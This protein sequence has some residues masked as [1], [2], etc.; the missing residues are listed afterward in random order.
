MVLSEVYDNWHEHR[1]SFA[2]VGLEDVEEVVVLE[3]AHRSVCYLQVDAADTSD[4]AFE[5]SRYQHFDLFNLAYFEHLL[6]FSQEQRLLHT[7]SEGPILEEA[8]EEWNGKG[9]VL[10]QEEHGASEELLVELG[11]S[12]NFV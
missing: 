4:D 6:Q 10:G 3:E 12:L 5:K 11:A 9:T 7:I 8:F 2:F 1:E